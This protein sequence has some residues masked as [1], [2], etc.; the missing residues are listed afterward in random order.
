MKR[1]LALATIFAA[2]ARAGQMH[3]RNRRPQVRLKRLAS[4]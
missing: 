2:L 4:P 3:M 1:M